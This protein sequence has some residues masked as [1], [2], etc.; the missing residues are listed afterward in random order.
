MDALVFGLLRHA[1]QLAAG[2][3][4]A[5]GYMDESM[6]ESVVGGAIAIGSA[7]WFAAGKIRS[8]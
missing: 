6:T 4:V 3:L 5:R 7:A 2:F 8:K 1:L